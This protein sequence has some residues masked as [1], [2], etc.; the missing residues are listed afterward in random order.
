MSPHPV[1]LDALD[2]KAAIL[3]PGLVVRKDLVRRM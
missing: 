3:L 2:E 1:R